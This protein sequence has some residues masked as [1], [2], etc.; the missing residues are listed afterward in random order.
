MKV[1]YLQGVLYVVSVQLHE[2][3]VTAVTDC[4]HMAVI[5]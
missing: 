5:Q 2:K 1:K 4:G 3:D